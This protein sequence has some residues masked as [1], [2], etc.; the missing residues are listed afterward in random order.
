MLPFAVTLDD[1]RLGAEKEICVLDPAA[2][3]TLPDPPA[4][5]P[6][7]T[8]TDPP[9]AI[10]PAPTTGDPLTLRRVPFIGRALPTDN[11]I[12]FIDGVA[13]AHRRAPPPTRSRSCFPT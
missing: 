9:I 1:L 7:F 6:I 2:E 4:T 12:V 10:F 8:I 11:P 13:R 3:P 5:D